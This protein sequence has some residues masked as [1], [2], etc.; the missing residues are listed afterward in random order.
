LLKCRFNS[1]RHVYN[2]TMPQPNEYLVIQAWGEMMRSAPTHILAEQERAAEAN[3]PLD[4]IYFVNREWV[5]I[6]EVTNPDA[7]RRIEERI[8][9]F[10][11]DRTV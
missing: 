7:R 3:A 11:K 6:N 5:S 4:S 9:E 2:G 10:R 8:I 1:F